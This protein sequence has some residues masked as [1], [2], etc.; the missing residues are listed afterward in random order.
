M[1]QGP[2]TIG[3]PDENRVFDELGTI[4]YYYMVLWYYVS[5]TFVYHTW[6]TANRRVVIVRKMLKLLLLFSFETSTDDHDRKATIE[7]IIIYIVYTHVR[8]IIIMIHDK[9]HQ[10]PSLIYRLIYD[11]NGF[12]FYFT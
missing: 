1:Q 5:C 9:S 12:Y 11:K 6:G 10:S 8:H 4:N 2:A 3:R 7:T